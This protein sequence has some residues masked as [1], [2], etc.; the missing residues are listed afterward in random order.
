MSSN[1]DPVGAGERPG[2]MHVLAEGEQAPR[3][4]TRAFTPEQEARVREI[5]REEVE[6]GVLAGVGDMDRILLCLD[7]VRAEMSLPADPA[8]GR[9]ER[10]LFVANLATDQANAERGIKTDFAGRARGNSR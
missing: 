7:F 5:A 1:G 4:V 3:Y 10:M 8:M 9:R 6:F 2:V